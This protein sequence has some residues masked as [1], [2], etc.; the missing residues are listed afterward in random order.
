METH[1]L[2]PILERSMLPTWRFANFLVWFVCIA[3]I[4][5]ESF[6]VVGRSLHL[7]VVAFPAHPEIAGVSNRKRTSFA[8]VCMIEA[9]DSSRARDAENNREGEFPNCH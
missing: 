2:D 1:G 6:L 9:T 4:V 7:A 5:D 8:A 3:H